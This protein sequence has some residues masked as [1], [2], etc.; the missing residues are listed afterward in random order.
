M[1]KRKLTKAVALLL[2]AV[3]ATSMLA[4]CGGSNDQAKNGKT[5]LTM[6]CWDSQQAPVME[7]MGEA[8]TKENPNVE[9]DV[10]VTTWTEYWTKLEASV[11][12]G[13]PADILWLNVLHIEEYVDAGILKDLTKV[14]EE[15]SVREHYPEALV[16]G[17]TVD[18][19]L[20]AIPKDFDTNGIFFN[21]EIFDKA[22]VA[23]PTDGM[24][25]DDFVAKCKELKEAGLDKG[26]YP[27]AINRNSGQ[28]TYYSSVD[29]NGGY[30]LSDDKTTSGWGETET[31]EAIRP[32]LQIVKDGLSPNLQQMSDT[33]PDA[34]FGAG[35]LA[36]Y[37]A[38]N[39]MIPE[40]GSTLDLKNIGVVQR[41]TFNGK[42]TDIINGLG[43]AV[44]EGTK[45]EEE[46]MKFVAWLGGEE[47]MKIQAEGGVV[48]SARNDA[49]QLYL[50]AY[51]DMNLGIFL[52][53]L[54]Q[55]KL[56]DF[57]KI[58]SE[59]ST[60][61]K[62]YLDKAWTGEMELEE[63]CKTIAQEEQ[64]LLDKMNGK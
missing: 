59:L 51:P 6:A 17:Y 4:G 27:T 61:E 23:Y 40:F 57:C 16:D 49:Q 34:M 21:K 30:L 18:G 8:Y 15:I 38:G 42:N 29:A 46:A 45:H 32:W 55:T 63:A 24:T 28:T 9:I 48:I 5:T 60:I 2:S 52:A 41:P 19:K 13:T 10:Q 1:S 53:N 20:Y 43:Y 36:M 14:G 56:F 47:A 35:K 22:G 37:I 25:F 26:V 50:N 11:T 31:I 54:D 62:T 3:M 12:G 33:S 44:A 39:Y 58:T 7:K 64:P